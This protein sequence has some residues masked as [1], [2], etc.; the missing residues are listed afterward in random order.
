MDT[1]PALLAIIGLLLALWTAGAVWAMLRASGREQKSIASRQVAQRLSRLIEE[2]PAIP[3][4]VRA[5]GRIEAPDRLARWIGLDK[6]PEY[7]SELAGADGRGLTEAQM[8]DLTRNVRRTQKTAKPFRM[9][10]TVAP[11]LIQSPRIISA[12]PTAAT[13]ISARRQTPGRSRVR[14]CAIVTVQLAAS[15]N[16]AK[17]TEA[18]VLD[19]VL[20]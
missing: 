7:M 5:D 20:K 18:V 4:L 11:G 10:I 17:D 14:E 6:V 2:A 16:A 8:D 15:S 19:S 9:A 3:L 1:S 13:R 12:R